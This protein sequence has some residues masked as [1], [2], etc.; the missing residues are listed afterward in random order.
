MDP[1]C[2]QIRIFW[3]FCGSN[4]FSGPKFYSDPKNVWTQNSFQHFFLSQNFF[5]PKGILL[6]FLWTRNYSRPKVLDSSKIF[7]SFPSLKE[8][9]FLKIWNTINILYFKLKNNHCTI[10]PNIFSRNNVVL[11]LKTFLI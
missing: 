7:L 6:K 4:I 10:L 5:E 11:S 2:F 9:I 3:T 8:S 1:K